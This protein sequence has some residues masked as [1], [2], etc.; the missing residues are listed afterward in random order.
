MSMQ[1]TTWRILI[2]YYQHPFRHFLLWKNY[3]GWFSYSFCR[4]FVFLVQQ[5]QGKLMG[6]KQVE[7]IWSYLYVIL[8]GFINSLIL[9]SIPCA[10]IFL[11]SLVFLMGKWKEG[12]AWGVIS[13]LIQ[14]IICCIERCRVVLWSYHSFNCRFL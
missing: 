5:V 13:F 8:E 2:Q 11:S 14:N 3:L 10:V 6:S 1:K 12:I 4:H 7:L 9:A